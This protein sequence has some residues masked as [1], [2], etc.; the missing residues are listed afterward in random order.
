MGKRWPKDANI[1]RNIMC[2][3]Y[4]Y[5]FIYVCVRNTYIMLCILYIYT[6]IMMYLFF[7]ADASC[8]NSLIENIHVIC[9]RV[10]G[11]SFTRLGK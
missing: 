1:P 4:L 3:I 11:K 9:W 5:I 7:F 8:D 2:D 10:M 6:Y